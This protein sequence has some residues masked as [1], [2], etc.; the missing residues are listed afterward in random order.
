MYCWVKLFL[1]HSFY[2]LSLFYW[3]YNN[4][5]WY[6]TL[7]LIQ[8]QFCNNHGFAAISHVTMLFCLL[9]DRCLGTKRG[10]NS[11]PVTRGSTGGAKPPLKDYFSSQEK[12]VG[13]SWKLL[14]IVGHR[15]ILENFSPH[16]VPQAGYGPALGLLVL[17]N[18]QFILHIVF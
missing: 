4:R 2:S 13:H 10:F 15:P 16:L 5:Y 17:V 9:L 1:Q 7:L 6:C 14:D 12:R 3:N 18:A 11:R 8:L